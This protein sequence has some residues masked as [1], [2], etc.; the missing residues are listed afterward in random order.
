MGSAG[1]ELC[2]NFMGL[3]KAH[4]VKATPMPH[5]LAGN[6]YR[7]A[8]RLA[9]CSFPRTCSGGSPGL[10]IVEHLSLVSVCNRTEGGVTLPC[11]QQQRREERR[12]LLSSCPLHNGIKHI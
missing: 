4:S 9:L 8:D 2:A 6:G 12:A 5:A 10:I 1:M 7:L 11:P 3:R